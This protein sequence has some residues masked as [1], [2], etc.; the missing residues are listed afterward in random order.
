MRKGGRY[1]WVHSC[2]SLFKVHQEGLEAWASGLLQTNLMEERSR[3]PHPGSCP[4]PDKVMMYR[5]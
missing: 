3:R 1:V 4:S 5:V 2:Q